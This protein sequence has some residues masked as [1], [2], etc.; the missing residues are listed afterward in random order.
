[1]KRD[2]QS[3]AEGAQNPNFLDKDFNLIVLNTLGEL[4]ESTAKERKEIR[5]VYEQIRKSKER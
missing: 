1:M 2:Q 5:T 3:H 4:M